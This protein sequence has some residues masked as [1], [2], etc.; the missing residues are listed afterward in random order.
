[1][2]PTNKTQST[3][4]LKQPKQNSKTGVLITSTNIY[5]YKIQWGPPTVFTP[6]CNQPK[7][8]TEHHMSNKNQTHGPGKGKAHGPNTIEISNCINSKQNTRT[9]GSNK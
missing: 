4:I 6:T 5:A 1:M 9:H 2:S 3:L 8:N 7:Q